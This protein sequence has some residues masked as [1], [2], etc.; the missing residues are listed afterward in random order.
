VGVK[1]FEN[2][3]GYIFKKNTSLR[4]PRITCGRFWFNRGSGDQL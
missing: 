2:I 3:F 4:L 1:L